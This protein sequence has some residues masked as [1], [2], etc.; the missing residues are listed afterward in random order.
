VRP[1][2]ASS[3]L[4]ASAAQAA[5]LVALLAMHAMIV[6]CRTIPLIPS[7]G[8]EAADAGAYGSLPTSAT[9][10]AVLRPALIPSLVEELLSGT[11]GTSRLKD[12]L[13]RTRTA[14]IAF[15]LPAEG[16]GGPYYALFSGTYAAA[17]MRTAIGSMKGVKKGKGWFVLEDGTALAIPSGRNILVTNADM[18]SF[19]KRFMEPGKRTEG[20]S[21]SGDP[22]AAILLEDSGRSER[23]GIA[24][25][26]GQPSALASTPGMT[27]IMDIP[28]RRLDVRA[29][30][31]DKVLEAEIAFTFDSDDAARI[32]LPT[33]RVL[34]A[35]ILRATGLGAGSAKASREG[36]VDALGGIRVQ[37][38]A[39]AA[40]VK[41]AMGPGS[42]VK[43]P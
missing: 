40:L 18:A 21:A 2:P 6:S 31:A 36:D 29:R 27:G 32:F 41:K 42:G 19:M 20:G 12:I 13:R 10:H 26:C 34:G 15:N 8:E 14:Y 22:I 1:R 23:S 16:R 9:F 28:L 7:L 30:E 35:G 5:I 4:T 11:E 17:G 25:R 39:F 3:R 38:S 37:P 43:A 33:V 24:L